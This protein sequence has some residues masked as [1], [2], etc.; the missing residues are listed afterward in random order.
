MA[1]ITDDS[2]TMDIIKEIQ[3]KIHAIQCTL[4]FVIHHLEL[5]K[6][7]SESVYEVGLDK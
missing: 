3:E 4:G 7:P 6:K 2:S 1:T 5:D